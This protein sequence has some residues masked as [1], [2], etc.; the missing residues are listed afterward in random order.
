[1]NKNGEQ[2]RVHANRI[3]RHETAQHE[4]ETRE[5]GHNDIRGKGLFKYPGI[6]KERAERCQNDDERSSAQAESK[7]KCEDKEIDGERDDDWFVDRSLNK[8][9]A[10]IV[11]AVDRDIEQVVHDIPER[12]NHETDHCRKNKRRR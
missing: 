4:A 9:P 10:R 5:H 7:E 1:M 12:A 11:D 8:R 3:L 2:E 6:Q